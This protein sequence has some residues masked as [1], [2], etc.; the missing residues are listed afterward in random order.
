MKTFNK[1]LFLFFA[2]VLCRL[3]AFA[4]DPPFTVFLSDEW[5]TKKLDELSL[6]EKIA[7]LMMITVYPEQNEASKNAI[8]E[9]IENYSPGG[10]LVMKGNPTKTASWI[11]Q[12]QEQIKTPLLVAIDGEW[13]L[14]MRMD[15]TI[16]YPN[17]QAL[18]AIQDSTFIYQMGRDLGIQLKKMGIHINFAPVADV[19]TNPNNP[20]IN[21]R[22][23]G[24]NKMNVAQKTWWMA[25]G[26]QN[27]GIIPVAKHFPGHGD[28]KTDSHKALPLIQHSKSRIDS[29]ETFPFRYLSEKGISAI[30]SAHLNVPSLDKSGTP[31]SLSKAIITD[32]LKT[33]IG[34]SGFIFTDAINMQGVR[35][36][37]GNAE[38]EAL[39]AGNDMVEFVPDIQKAI[40]SVLNAI[41]NNEISETEINEKCKKVL[42]LKR[43]VGLNEYK[44]AVTKNLVSTLNS[45]YYEVVN[46]KLIESSL[47]V[48]VNQSILP[49]ENLETL[50]IASVQVG[51]KNTSDFQKMLSKYTDIDHFQLDKNGSEQDWANI[52]VQLKNYNLVLVG[53]EGIHI[54]PSG[55]YGTT[56]I[57]RK[58]VSEIIQ[59][60]NTIVT[61]FGNAYA[62]Q[63]FENIHRAKALILA[64]QNKQ[65]T[66]EL[67][68][69][70][71]FGA[72]D[73]SGKLPVSVDKR[74]KLNDGIAIKK[75]NC[76]AYTIPEEVGID[77][78][79]L[80]KKI[81]SLANLGIRGKAFP[82]C[83]V[84]IA[85]NGK[86]IFHKSY[87]FHTYEK[88]QLLQ[89]SDIYDWASITKVTGP[90][91]AIMKLVDEGKINID[92]PLSFYYPEF[93]NSNK[94]KLVLREILA[95]Q[96]QLAAWI[97]FW[98]MAIDKN[99]ELDKNVFKTAPSE[100]Y[101]IRI[102]GNLY[103]NKAFRKTMFDTIR[104]SKLTA[105][106]RYLYSGLSFYIYPQIIENITQNNYEDYLKSNFYR[107]LGANTITYNAY[108]HFPL[109]E[110]VPT[111]NDDF[112]RKEKLQ[113][114]V[115]DE[116][117]SMMGGI[118]G[119]AG[120]FGNTN[121]LA[122]LFQMYLQ[123]GFYGGKRYISEA[124]FKEFTKIQY[125]QLKNRRGLG[126]DKPLIDNYKNTFKNAYPAVDSSEKSFGHTGYTG[127][128]AWADPE[129]NLLFIFMSNRVQPT[130]ENEKLYQLNIRT[131][132]HQSIY[133]CIKKGI[134]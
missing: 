117:A 14:A 25:K 94:E 90:L 29:I 27:V 69:Q 56:E 65:L 40:Q 129:N 60:N 57:Q 2:I 73:A 10:I 70:L 19:S 123:M 20:V 106:K 113:G 64:Y 71:V 28:T 85:K 134:Q 38:V 61:F 16:Q 72:N 80:S 130:R 97:P 114:F 22:S 99:G 126:F 76:L 44:N 3:Q 112:F 8:L 68:A 125:P 74:F 46:R 52:Q 50:K 41:E 122:K 75:N 92:E 47:T 4:V 93:K 35:T 115:H 132:M 131:A 33:E 107:P 59:K 54:Y 79:I 119:N 37:K 49:V 121:D 21:F 96:A 77:S 124:T 34:F 13:G 36:K 116:G 5:V 18:G 6:E 63:Y 15:S 51:N 91:P 120:L 111:E 82:G 102:S 83:Q 39:K 48:L 108:L 42:A 86:V 67:A 101:N 105:R 43:W 53:V 103:M 23:F 95:H 88:K 55:K 1:F 66:Q 104:N 87:G 84:L 58:A 7:Q 110:I 26:M 31:S 100:D 127:T 118:S 133:D 62:L 17:A 12:F 89:T 109:K 9:L 24:E 11:N 32:Y 78:K 45:P 81:D 128:L 30:M 98:Q